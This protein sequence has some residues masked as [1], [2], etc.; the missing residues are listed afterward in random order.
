MF[1]KTVLTLYAIL[2]S[3]LSYCQIDHLI[4]PS[5][6]HIS[7]DSI[8]ANILVNSL[9]SFLKQSVNA[10]KENTFVSKS[11][12]LETSCLLDE[13]KGMEDGNGADKKGFF[14]CYLTNVVQLDSTDYTVQIAY[15]GI[16]DESPV[17]RASFKLMAKKIADG[18]SFSSPLK[19]NTENCKVKNIGNFNFY[20]RTNINLA[21]LTNYVNKTAE[22][23]K[24]LNAHA[25]NTQLYLCS[26][27]PQ[28]LNLLGVTYKL[29]YNGIENNTLTSFENNN[30]LRMVG[31]NG[32]NNKVFDI[33]DLWHDRLHHVIP[34]S[35]INKPVDEG[36]AYL[37]GGSWGISWPDIFKQFK[38]Y[39]GAN[40][41]WLTAFNENKNFGPS[42]QY[43]L[44]V[45]YVINALLV[46]KIEKEKGVR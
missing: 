17:F 46:K 2:I 16:K 9:E 42:P 5:Y 3:T 29:D 43:H 14:K 45:S 26:D 8:K 6:V 40:K 1:K 36:C 21:I 27:F 11:E 37:Y 32:S 20:Y 38:T 28:L 4:V 25:Y 7:M 12:L 39:M 13:I 31:A 23:D 44:Y 10:N 19:T 22:F 30:N 24:K 33:H 41:E 15:I 35:I 34:I 18:Y